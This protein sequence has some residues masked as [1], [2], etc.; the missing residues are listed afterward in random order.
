MTKYIKSFGG[1]DSQHAAL[2]ALIDWVSEDAQEDDPIFTSADLVSPIVD[3]ALLESLDILFTPKLLNVI[4]TA[5][6]Q[7]NNP[8]ARWNSAGNPDTPKTAL[9][10]LALDDYPGQRELVAWNT[11]TSRKTLLNLAKDSDSS[12]STIAQCRLA[13]GIGD[14]RTLTQSPNS[15]LAHIVIARDSRTPGAF[16]AEMVSG[17]LLKHLGR[18][19]KDLNQSSTLQSEYPHSVL[20]AI[21]SNPNL[22]ADTAKALH[23][24]DESLY[25]YLAGNPSSPTEMLA[26]MSQSQW[27]ST[28]KH[29]ADN[30]KT[31]KTT[32]LQ[33]V[34][35]KTLDVQA[36]A[37]ART[38]IPS[39]VLHN[40]L[41][42]PSATVRTAVARN[43]KTSKKDLTIL[44]TDSALAVRIAVAD[45]PQ[46]PTKCLQQ[47]AVDTDWRVRACTLW[48]SKPAGLSWL[49]IPSDP[50]SYRE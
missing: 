25:D 21:A 7:S 3:S 32:L 19:G 23:A 8:V 36:A 13:S 26:D 9:D 31:S 10:E 16:L 2:D 42:H 18:G 47:L 44:A 27:N 12:V 37:I 28:R 17:I 15:Q 20:A 40:F 11:N 1:V 33:L 49:D 50:S 4:L 38:E 14:R 46:A 48:N 43:L 45:N 6:A 29:C 22:D 30:P 5:F 41:S 39:D 34:N 35:D 24:Y